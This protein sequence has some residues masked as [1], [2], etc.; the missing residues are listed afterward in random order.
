[1]AAIQ[2]EVNVMRATLTEK[3]DEITPGRCKGEN[4]I[5]SN[6]GGA[7]AIG[8]VKLNRH[9]KAIKASEKLSDLSWCDSDHL[10]VA[11]QDGNMLVY[12]TKADSQPARFFHFTKSWLNQVEFNMHTAGTDKGLIAMGGLDNTVTVVTMDHHALTTGGALSDEEEPKNEKKY[13]KHGGPIYSIKWLD[14]ARF[15]SGSGDNTVM[16]WD[17]S[18]ARKQTITPVSEI[19]LHLGDVCDM[20]V[21]DSNTIYTASADRTSKM[22]DL[23]DNGKVVASF[24][25]HNL[26]VTQVKAFQG[27]TNMV[28]TAS[29]DR[30]VRLWDSRT[31]KQVAMYGDPTPTDEKERDEETEYGSGEIHAL[32]LSSSGRIAMIGRENGDIDHLDLVTGEINPAGK[33]HTSRVSGLALSPDGMAYASCSRETAEAKPTNFAIWA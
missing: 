6:N 15:I 4:L 18:E 28:V 10:C 30:T 7:A 33:L 32:E 1:M 5:L 29:E 20:F 25:G 13:T 26:G 9:G 8:G 14:Q 21:I 12:N 27:M 3:I 2:D 17:A 24:M 11:N 23:R 16:L 19:K 22:I 31:M